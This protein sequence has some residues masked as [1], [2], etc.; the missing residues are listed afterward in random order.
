M[1]G[2]V[3]IAKIDATANRNTASE[4]QIQGYPTMI[5]FPKGRKD[6]TEKY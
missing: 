5:F 2:K 6:K 1:K 4:Y 3:K